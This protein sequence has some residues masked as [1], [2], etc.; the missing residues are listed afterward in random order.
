MSGVEER[1]QRDL[2]PEVLLRRRERMALTIGG[3]VVLVL[4]A[5]AA[6]LFNRPGPPPEGEI[7]RAAQYAVAN[8]VNARGRLHFN[9]P[10]ETQISKIG[11]NVFE[12]RGWVLDVSESGIGRGYLFVVTV[13]HDSN[14]KLDYVRNVSVAEQ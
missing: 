6:Y 13:V 7:L 1:W 14:K 9:A 4:V 8:A 12:V 2:N 11:D 10:E 5:A 3:I